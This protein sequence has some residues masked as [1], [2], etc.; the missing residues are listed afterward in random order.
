[1]SDRDKLVKI[2]VKKIQMLMVIV[3]K[4]DEEKAAELI[5]LCYKMMDDKEYIA[6]KVFVFPGKNIEAEELL[7]EGLEIILNRRI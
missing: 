4:G 2:L 3:F 5:A 6:D 7:K 1:M